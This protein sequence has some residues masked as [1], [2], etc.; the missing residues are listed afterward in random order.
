MWRNPIDEY[1]HKWALRGWSGDYVDVRSV[2]Y[3]ET[4]RELDERWEDLKEIASDINTTR[5]ED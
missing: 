5:K 4:H 1:L 3:Y 2:E